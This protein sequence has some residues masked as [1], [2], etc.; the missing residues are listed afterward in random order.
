M[1]HGLY[2]I[3]SYQTPIQFLGKTQKHNVSSRIEP[4]RRIWYGVSECLGAVSGNYVWEQL[5]CNIQADTRGPIAQVH[6]T[7]PIIHG[8]TEVH[9]TEIVCA[10]VGT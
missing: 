6:Y 9:I 4:Y 3:L 10:Y 5:Q 7:H 8:V 2:C 1:G